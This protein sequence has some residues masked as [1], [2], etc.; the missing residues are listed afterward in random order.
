MS[1]DH[2]HSHA[3]AGNLK[4]AFL[5]N[6]GFTVLEFAAGVWTNS[7]AIQSDAIHDAG[8]CFALGLAWYLQRLSQQ[9]SDPK[10]T[11]GYRRLSSLG[12]L[13][14]GLVLLV[15]L[16]FVVWESVSRLAQPE[17]VKAPAVV[18][19]AVVGLLFNGTAAWRLS[20]GESLNEK[21][22]SWHLLEDTLGW[23]AVLVG[24]LVMS[25][26]DVP[27]I[28]PLL[29]LGIAVFVLWNVF[30]NLRKVALVF[31]QATPAGF[32]ADAFDRELATLPNVVGAHHTH[33]WTLDGESHVFSTHLVLKCDCTREDV[34]A[35]KRRVHE[36]LREHHFL[37]TSIEVEFEGENCAA[38]PEHC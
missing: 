9:R 13:I 24:G 31:L 32:D 12:A 6:L 34:V 14:T 3:A 23:A 29:A 1:H 19:V 35:V 37:H 10:F 7:V 25:F 4:I 8:D 20:G 36:L 30:R 2:N 17:A 27:I 16:S 11:Y 21:V 15:G 28:D 18:L 38:D 33:T 5:L 26:W 22:A